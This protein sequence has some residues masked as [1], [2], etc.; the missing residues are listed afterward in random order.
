MRFDDEKAAQVYVT[1]I[2]FGGTYKLNP[3]RLLERDKIV[4][5]RTDQ[6][7]NKLRRRRKTPR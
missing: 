4:I 5:T 3:S 7:Q 1:A 6:R 2:L